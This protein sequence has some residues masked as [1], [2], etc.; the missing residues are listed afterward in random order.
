[1]DEYKKA[2]DEYIGILRKIT[3]NEFTEIMDAK[4]E[5]E[6]CRSIQTV[7]RHVLRSGYSYAAY[8]LQA[9]K[10]PAE[11]PES[12]KVQADNMEDAIRELSKMF[13]F[14]STRLYESN[15]EII[16]GNMRTIRFKTRWDEYDIEQILE[17]AV[18]HILRHRRQI[19][20]FIQKQRGSI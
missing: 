12:E 8:V 13:D 19:S 4:T 15:R 7:T 18:V 1:M 16:E 20:R 2:L 9:L 5:D 11:I 10:I 3:M 17:H 6:D 14:N